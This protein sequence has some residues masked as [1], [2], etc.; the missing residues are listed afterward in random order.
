MAASLCG[1]GLF[2]AGGV[3]SAQVPDPNTPSPS[4]VRSQAP[5]LIPVQRGGRG[6]GRIAGDE[7]FQQEATNLSVPLEPPGNGR[8][9]RLES[10]KSYMQRIEQQ[11]LQ[12]PEHDR[13]EFPEEPPVSTEQ[14]KARTFPRVTE[15][16]EPNYLCYKRLYFEQLNAERYGWDLGIIHPIVSAGIFYWDLVTLP[17]HMGTEPFRKYECSAGYCLPGDPVPL[18]LYPPEFSVTGT[19]L[20]AGAIVS[21]FAIF[22]G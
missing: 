8:L 10:E 16:V 19:V 22:P 9:F 17:Y 12:G 15:L 7:A 3:V 1:L 14:Y 18:L 6:M 2:L 11:H 5:D 21:L 20:E 4:V 13:V